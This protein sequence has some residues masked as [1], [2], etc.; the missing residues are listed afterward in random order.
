MINKQQQQQPL[1]NNNSSVLTVYTAPGPGGRLTQWRLCGSGKLTV[2]RQRHHTSGE[3]QSW[4]LKH[5]TS[6]SQVWELV[7]F[8]NCLKNFLRLMNH[9]S[10]G[11]DFLGQRVKHIVDRVHTQTVGSHRKVWESRKSIRRGKC[12]EMRRAYIGNWTDELTKWEIRS[13][14]EPSGT[15]AF[16]TETQRQMHRKFV[17]VCGLE[18]WCG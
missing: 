14:I 4:S 7:L 5:Y 3:S 9:A 1:N 17:A 18:R 6:E 15:R 13:Y 12:E 10:R 11:H 16:W 8:S 2:G